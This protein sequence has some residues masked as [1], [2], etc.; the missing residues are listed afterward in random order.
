[1]KKFLTESVFK[2]KK[3]ENDKANR[4]NRLNK[5]LSR[6]REVNIKKKE[7]NKYRKRE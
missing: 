6:A 7:E 5:R 1:M 3:D 4:M 2:T